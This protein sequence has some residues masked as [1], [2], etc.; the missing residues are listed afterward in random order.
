MSTPH[1]AIK[2][3]ADAKALAAVCISACV[4]DWATRSGFNGIA[5]AALFTAIPA[6]LVATKR[7]VNTP[8]V[9]ALALTPLFGIWLAIRTSAWL[10]V[11]DVLVTLFLLA[12]A[13]SFG[14]GGS[15]LKLS[16]PRCITRI[17]TLISHS[18]LAPAFFW[19]PIWRRTP[20]QIQKAKPIITGILI[21]APVVLLLF[22]LLASADTVF[23]SLF[24]LHLN[25][26][27]VSSHVVLLVIG[28]WCVSGL[29]RSA[30]ADQ[31]HT[32]SYNWRLG[33]VEAITG[34]ATIVALYF[35]FVATQ[36]VVWL[37][38]ANHLL[39]THGLTYAEHARHGFFQLLA[40]AAITLVLIMALK[41]A[42][43]PS[44]PTQ[45]FWWIVFSETAIVLTLAI[46]A[47]AVQRLFM[48]EHAYG[49]TMLRLYST[50]FA[51]WVGVVFAILSYTLLSKSGDQW[52]ITAVTAT[53]LVLLFGLNIINPEKLVVERNVSRLS[54]SA[55]PFDYVYTSTLSDDAVPSMAASL[56]NLNQRDRQL[57]VNAICSHQE[58]GMQEFAA[59]NFSRSQAN[60]ELAKVCPT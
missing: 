16:A 45:Q 7:F 33:S 38:G 39:K 26:G 59:T 34:L 13:A 9:V 43:T 53:G 1:L 27:T 47:V 36:I 28:G 56:P 30:S 15:V 51:V 6:M 5:G 24:Q 46:V 50:I 58:G 19:S 11:P 25:I 20:G 29:L 14:S 49:L 48:Y 55:V 2:K 52:F 4:F 57:M 40:V 32:S 44:T 41:A 17:A 31:P 42:V 37:G 60:K 10:L 54:R 22:A 23:A 8:A 3:P 21:A 18:V 12:V 35:V